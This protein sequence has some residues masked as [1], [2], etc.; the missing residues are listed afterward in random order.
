MGGGART[1]VGG[2][3]VGVSGE[4]VGGRREGDTGGGRAGRVPGGA[5][6]E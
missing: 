2:M 5:C 6:G 3:G 4:C 1:E